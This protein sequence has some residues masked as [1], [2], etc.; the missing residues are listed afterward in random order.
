MTETRT[1]VPGEIEGFLSGCP[2]C[3]S[4]RIG[5][6]EVGKRFLI[7]SGLQ[8][9]AIGTVVEWHKDMPKIKNEFMAQL[10]HEPSEW[11]TRISTKRQMIQLFPLAPIPEWAPPLCMEDAGELHKAIIGFC[12]RS[13]SNGRWKTD[14][15]SFNEVVR[16]AW[17]NRLPVEPDEL[18]LVLKAH[19]VPDKSKKELVEFYE[20]GRN[21]LVYAIGRRP[22]KKKRVEPLSR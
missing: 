19:G 15:S 8:T 9:G 18:W 10:D 11:Q 16:S 2:F 14:W 3:A 22:V 5:I 17:Y 6:P 12:E 7:I 4:Y 13:F 1:I 20:K 21:L